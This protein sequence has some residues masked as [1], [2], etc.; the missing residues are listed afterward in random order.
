MGTLKERIN[1]CMERSMNGEA[2]PNDSREMEAMI[3]YLKWLSE[4]VPEDIQEIYKG[5]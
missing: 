3:A 1:G 5:T 2:L 4:G